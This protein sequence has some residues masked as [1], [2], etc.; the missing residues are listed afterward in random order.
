MSYGESEED[1][2]FIGQSWE[3]DDAVEDYASGRFSPLSVQPSRSAIIPLPAAV[4]QAASDIVV[5]EDYTGEGPLQTFTPVRL[6]GN[7]VAITRVV[8]PDYT[9]ED[10][11]GLGLSE[12]RIRQAIEAHDDPIVMA[13]MQ[14]KT[15][16]GTKRPRFVTAYGN[17]PE[18]AAVSSDV[19][20]A[21]EAAASD[22]GYKRPPKTMSIED[23]MGTF[24]SD[25]CLEVRG[26]P[27]DK[28]FF[29]K[30]GDQLEEITRRVNA[31]SR[32]THKHPCEFDSYWDGYRKDPRVKLQS[33]S[34][35]WKLDKWNKYC[36]H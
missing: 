34:T 28:T 36:C 17:A 22:V 33:N 12:A 14:G 16:Q 18:Y 21:E 19:Q 4:H 11:A 25:G 23:V 29:C 9:P 10:Y 2:D 8:M 6:L 26:P 13:A 30:R 35:T 7:P 20:R 27:E 31:K 5:D 32:K 1:D 24:C 15:Y 3:L